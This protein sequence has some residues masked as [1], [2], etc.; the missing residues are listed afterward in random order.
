MDS[1]GSI[2]FL[3]LFGLST[4]LTYL[5]IRR[6][7]TRALPGASLGAV[8]NSVFLMLYALVKGNLFLAALIIGVALGLLF[9]VLTVSIALFFRNNPPGAHT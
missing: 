1:P 7:W 5:A 6:G 8:A 3:A 4:V 9:T 2:I